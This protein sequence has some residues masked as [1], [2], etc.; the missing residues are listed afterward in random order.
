MVMLKHFLTLI[1]TNTKC[2]RHTQ[3]FTAMAKVEAGWAVTRHYIA[4]EDTTAIF[5]LCQRHNLV[6]I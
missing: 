1:E 6:N 5:V 2:P 3:L 4:V